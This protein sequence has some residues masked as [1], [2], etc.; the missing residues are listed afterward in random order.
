MAYGLF[1]VHDLTT[2]DTTASGAFPTQFF[3]WRLVDRTRDEKP[4]PT[5]EA[6]GRKFGGIITTPSAAGSRW[7]SYIKVDDTNVACVTSGGGSSQQPVSHVEGLDPTA[8]CLD[9]HGLIGFAVDDTK[10][11]V[12]TAIDAGASMETSPTEFPEIGTYAVL[13]DPFGA[14]FALRWVR[15]DDPRRQL[16]AGGARR[17]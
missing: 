1:K 3:D 10:S 13:R 7:L 6:A 4:Y 15:L 16:W 17:P 14:R 2:P 12:E 9:I 11:T 8:I 5:T